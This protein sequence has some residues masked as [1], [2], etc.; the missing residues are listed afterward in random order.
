MKIFAPVPEK[1]AVANPLVY[2]SPLV[3][4]GDGTAVIII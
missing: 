3:C 2:T 1:P 4:T